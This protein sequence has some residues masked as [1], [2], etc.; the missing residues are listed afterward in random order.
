MT[1]RVNK[2][3][4]LAVILVTGVGQSLGQ[5]PNEP[6]PPRAAGIE[7]PGYVWNEEAEEKLLALKAEGNAIRGEISYEV[8]Q[9]CHGFKAPGDVEGYYPRLAG[10]H[11][12]VLIKQMTDVR[13]GRRDNPTEYPFLTE[14]VINVQDIAD[15]AA[16]LAGLPVTPDNGKGPGEDLERGQALYEEH[17]E[18]CHG[19]DGEGDAKEFYPRVSGQHYAYLLRESRDIRDGKRRNSNPDMVEAIEDYT[20]EDLIVVSDYMSRLPIDSR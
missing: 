13:A 20:E 1:E 7:S 18:T 5:G 17:C 8:C 6:V 16:Y 2:K 9:G 12:S 4:L 14:H 11:A 3:I 10:Q 19:A 15:I